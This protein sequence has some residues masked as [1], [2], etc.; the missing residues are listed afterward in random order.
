M[1]HHK[2]ENGKLVRASRIQVMIDNFYARNEPMILRVLDAT[3]RFLLKVRGETRSLGAVA[4][5]RYSF[6]NRRGGHY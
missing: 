4:V 6:S 5:T 3:T 2:V 1:A